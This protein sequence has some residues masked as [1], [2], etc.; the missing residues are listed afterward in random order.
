ME[1]IQILLNKNIIKSVEPTSTIT[2]SPF[3]IASVT[4]PRKIL[5]LSLDNCIKLIE[6][7]H[8]I[9]H[10]RAI[11][12]Y[13]DT[14]VTNI[15]IPWDIVADIYNKDSKDNT[16][17][18]IKC[19]KIWRVQM[20][21]I[22]P[23]QQQNRIAFPLDITEDLYNS[24]PNVYDTNHPIIWNN[25]NDIN[26]PNN[27]CEPKQ[28]PIS[29]LPY[30]DIDSDIDDTGIYSTINTIPSHMLLFDQPIAY[31]YFTNDNIINSELCTPTLI[32]R[33][34]KFQG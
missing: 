21:V 26:D 7:I 18:S 28:M 1:E 19:H 3:K 9:M 6:I 2:L 14:C 23:S 25:I 20:Y 15:D 4:L 30:D 17:T 10:E 32:T 5:D 34:N 22:Y 33:I 27:C 13:K 24:I 8:N 12:W 29:I 16:I 31:Q 11:K